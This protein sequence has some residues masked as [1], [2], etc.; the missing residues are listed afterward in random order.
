MCQYLYCFT[1]ILKLYILNISNKKIFTLKT[2]G[3]AVSSCVDKAAQSMSL[4]GAQAEENSEQPE[5]MLT[6]VKESS[7]CLPA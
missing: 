4:D 6:V 1:P 5:S 7:A 3:M 2:V